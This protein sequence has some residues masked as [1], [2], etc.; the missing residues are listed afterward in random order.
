MMNMFVCL[1]QRVRFT[2][3]RAQLHP[4]FAYLYPDGSDYKRSRIL[5]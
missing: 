4:V 5:P 3:L 1:A 2:M